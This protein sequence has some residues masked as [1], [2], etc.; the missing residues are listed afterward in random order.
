MPKTNAAEMRAA[1]HIADLL[2]AD[3]GTI[4]SVSTEPRFDG[5]ALLED[6][7]MFGYVDAD[8][9]P[10][11]R[12]NEATAAHFHGLGSSRHP[13]MPYWSIPPSVSGDLARLRQAA[14]EAADLAHLA[15]SFGL[16]ERYARLERVHEE[17]AGRSNVTHLF[18]LSLLTD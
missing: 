2:A 17:S 8:G 11:L 14:D 6:G 1:R 10:Y 3:I 16:S 7:V 15:Y 4:G 18:P 5:V 12:A 9:T 13:Q